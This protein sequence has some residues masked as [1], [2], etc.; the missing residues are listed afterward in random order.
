MLANP[1]IART[2]PALILPR[3]ACV[4]NSRSDPSPRGLRFRSRLFSGSALAMEPN[5]EAVRLHRRVVRAAVSGLR[6]AFRAQSGGDGDTAE[7]V[8]NRFPRLLG[9][10]ARSLA[11]RGATAQ[12]VSG[13]AGARRLP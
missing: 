2:L 5:G 3:D 13:A 1:L 12:F 6:N 7:G 10:G 4:R 9:T 11:R 8:G